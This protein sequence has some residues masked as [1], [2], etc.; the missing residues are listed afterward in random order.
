MKKLYSIALAA[1]VA[2]SASASSPEVKQINA[3]KAINKATAIATNIKIEKKASDAQPMKV[4]AANE[5]NTID[6]IY[7]I[8]IGDYYISDT[9]SSYDADATIVD[10]GDG[11]ITIECA[12]FLTPVTAEYD[13]VNSTVTFKT[14]ATRIPVPLTNGATYYTAFTPF[15]WNASAKKVVH[16]DYTVTYKDGAFDFPKDHGFSWPAY[17]TQDDTEAQGYFSIFDVESL[18][19]SDAVLY[20][21]AQ[22]TGNFLTNLFAGTSAVDPVSTTVIYTEA[23]KTYKIQDAFAATYKQLGFSGVSPD[24]KVVATDPDNC[25]VPE[26]TTYINGGDKDGIYFVLSQSANISDP[27]TL[28]EAYRIKL[29]DDG[30]TITIVFPIRSILLWPSNTTTVHPANQV[31]SKLVIKKQTSGINSAVVEEANEAPVYYNLQGVRV[32]EP[33]NGLFIE[34]RGNKAVKVLK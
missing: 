28:D 27:S 9:P 13:A 5:N 19:K 30:K 20:E 3:T 23:T 26:T 31:E 14:D 32:A 16:G 34:V 8:T 29:T 25:L 2:F 15:A 12:D 6:G 21:D 18:A 1:A 17:A 24:V 11:T 10:N 4:A 22:W 33:T 7:T